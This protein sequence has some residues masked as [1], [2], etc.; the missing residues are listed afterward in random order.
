MQRQMMRESGTST[1]CSSSVRQSIRRFAQVRNSSQRIKPQVPLLQFPQLPPG[2][3]LAARMRA[4]QASAARLRAEAAVLLQLRS[5]FRSPAGR[6][7]LMLF[8]SPVKPI[9]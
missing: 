5:A 1:N 7:M 2:E 3:A 9:L 8:F 6:S 4:P